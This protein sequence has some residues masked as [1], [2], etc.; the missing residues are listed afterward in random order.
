MVANQQFALVVWTVFVLTFLIAVP[1]T[2]VIFIFI[3]FVMDLDFLMVASS[4]LADA[5]GHHAAAIGL[6]KTAGASCFVAGI[7]GW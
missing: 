6:K 7:I 3:F 2:N 4:Y 1:S 5:D